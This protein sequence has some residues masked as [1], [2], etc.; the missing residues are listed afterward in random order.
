MESGLKQGWILSTLL[1]NLYLNDL[2]TILST[3]DKGI[4]IDD[5]ARINHLCY[6]DDRI[7]VAETERDL[8]N[9]LDILAAW[10]KENC[11]TIDF[12]KTKAIHF[13]NKATVFSI[14][15]SRNTH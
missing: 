6:A 12:N 14:Y 11:M 4:M 15:M 7:L 8:Q 10:C 3:V 13:R 9:L 2:S 5:N 1:F